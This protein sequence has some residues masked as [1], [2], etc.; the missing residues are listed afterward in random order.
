[1]MPALDDLVPALGSALLQFL[2]QGALIGMLTALALRRLR[3]ASP[4]SR[5]V[6]ACLAMLA[7]LGVPIIEVL[8]RLYSPTFLDVVDVTGPIV[9]AVR[10]TGSVLSSGPIGATPTETWLSGIVILWA[11]GCSVLC[12]RTL[13]GL[14]W[15]ARMR[16][17][18]T[19]Q[20]DVLWQARVDR[21]ASRFG[22]VRR[23][24]L[25]VLD[26]LRTPFTTG[27]LRPLVVIPGVLLA[28]L[29]IRSVEAL[30]A[31]ELAHV[32]R[33][34]F[35][36]N[37]F[38][39]VIEALLFYHPVTWWLSR[40]IRIERELIADALA[41][42]ML[43]DPRDLAVA[44][45]ELADLQ[46]EH[47]TMPLLAQAATG[48]PLL[49][50]VRALMHS[51]H[52]QASALPMVLMF[53]AVLTAGIASQA[54]AR[55]AA[56]AARAMTESN[57]PA[58]STARRDTYVLVDDDGTSRGFGPEDDIGQ[59]AAARRVTP[60]EFLWV[61]RAGQSYIVTDPDLVARAQ[62]A[63]HDFDK[64]ETR[65]AELHANQDYS[66]RTQAL[67]RTSEQAA[68]V[69]AER[70]RDLTTEALASGLTRPA[71]AFMPTQ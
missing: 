66:A 30:I 31:H 50:R 69:A 1:M 29:P 20:W 13:F 68:D 17:A 21:L 2:W 8:A 46:Q 16:D 18:A 35:L 23:V 41:A 64:L 57:R 34:D 10:H 6:V 26:V 67:E 28:R 19:S 56:P 38:Q 5:Y 60:G 39:R 51:R 33:N 14:V 36:V 71:P 27:F 48:G 65:I 55:L 37:L 4:E 53:I 44:L 11:I 70:L 7:C 22:L 25:R 12:L 59:I 40:R 32:R 47:A 42:E 63:W 24:E 49:T 62:A 54:Y 45:A 3:Q 52:R 61:H 43:D 58:P 15:V 9:A